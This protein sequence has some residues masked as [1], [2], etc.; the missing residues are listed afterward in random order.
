M[1]PV[2]PRLKRG[3]ENGKKG[4]V[5]VGKAEKRAE[6]RRGGRG[7]EKERGE[8]R[9]VEAKVRKGGRWELF[10]FLG[11]RLVGSIFLRKR[12]SR[13]SREITKY[14]HSSSSRS[15]VIHH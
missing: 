3:G 6:R 5:K 2:D 10:N 9:M 14:Q 15:A 7:W 13:L 8:G 1:P 11:A 12:T 4:E